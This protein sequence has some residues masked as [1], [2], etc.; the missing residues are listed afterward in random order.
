MNKELKEL[1]LSDLKRYG[2]NSEKEMSFS[3]KKELYGYRFT[4]HLRKAKYYKEH[5]KKIRFLFNRFMLSRY[6]EKYGFSISY[7]TNI[8]KGL[9]LGHIGS[10]VVNSAA[11]IGNNVN[12][13]QGVTIGVA[14]GERKSGV[15]TIGNNVWIGA[16]ATIVGGITIG[17]DVMIAPNTF[18]NFDVPSHS[19]VI[20]SKASIISKENATDK[21]IENRV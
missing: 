4:K 9:Y 15:P 11:V 14:H 20:F 5:N 19:V 21:Y 8:G 3:V 1:V 6:V 7:G 16:N 2:Y 17:D 18:V 10:I 12:L 13:S